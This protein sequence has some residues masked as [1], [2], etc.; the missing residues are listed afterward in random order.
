MSVLLKNWAYYGL[1][2]RQGDTI[3]LAN[4]AQIK[5]HLPLVQVIPLH[6]ADKFL[7]VNIGMFPHVDISDGRMIMWSGLPYLDTAATENYAGYFEECHYSALHLMPGTFF[8]IAA[9][10]QPDI[11][12]DCFAIVESATKGLLHASAILDKPGSHGKRA[13][14][15]R[16]L[17]ECCIRPGMHVA[18]LN[19]YRSP[20]P[21]SPHT[22]VHTSRDSI[23]PLSM[24]AR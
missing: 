4:S 3:I 19:V 13:L 15:F 21:L 5:D 7:W 18:T 14:E 10:E 8:V 20:V 22:R 1:V 23:V 17:R 2:I 16:A 24:A 6:A 9:E 12:N 11:P